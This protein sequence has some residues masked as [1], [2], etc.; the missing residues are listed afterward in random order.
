VTYILKVNDLPAA[1]GGAGGPASDAE[2]KLEALQSILV[3]G[4]GGPEPVPNFSLVQVVGCLAERESDN[5]WVLTGA[6]E[7]VRTGHPQRTDDD[8]PLEPAKAP[9]ARTV[10]LMVSP[11]FD[12]RPHKGTEVEARGF[13]IRRPGEDRINLTS[14]ETIRQRCVQ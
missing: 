12:P 5:A 6:S 11:A 2:L 13:L 1:S 14:L 7:P 9:G 8:P 10:D 4:E 3:T